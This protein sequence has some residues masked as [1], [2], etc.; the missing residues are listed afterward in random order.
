M[1]VGGVNLVGYLRTESGV[2][3]AARRTL[4]ALRRAGIPVEP[5]DVSELQVNR[6]DDRSLGRFAA[7]HPHEI[8]LVCA[9]VELHFALLAH[10]G[11]DFFRDRYNV[12]LWFWEQP[13]FPR[14]WH[15][16]L[17]WYD[18]VW[19]GSSFIA[20]ALAPISPIPVV[21]IPPVL[22]LVEPGSR[23]R[24]RRRL[25]VAP[26]TL[27]YLFLFDFHSH[28][29]RKNPLAVVEAFRQ[30]FVPTD[31][32]RLVL[33]CV[34][35]QSRPEDLAELRRRAVGWPVTIETGYW[36]AEEIRDLTAAS[37]AYVS[38]HRSEGVGL[39]LG[40][41]MALGKPVIA[42]GWSGNM[43]FMNVGN[44][45]PVRYELTELLENAGPY[46]AG[47][48][49]AEPSIEH[50]AELMRRVLEN[51][52]EA[53]A[54]GA[55]ARREIAAG[56]SEDAVAG[57][58]GE[59]L[60][61][62]AIRRRLDA[63]REEARTEY[64]RYRRLPERLGEA[65][66][67]T[68]PP[69]AVVAVVSKGDEALV[70]IEGRTGWHFPRDRDGA[71]PGYYP[72][73]GEAAVEHLEA[74]RAAGAGFLLIPRTA[75]W[76]LEHYHDFRRHL[77]GRYRRLWHDE[78]CV[79]Y[80]LAAGRQAAEMGALDDLTA[81]VESLARRA[82][83]LWA[84]LLAAGEPRHRVRKRATARPAF[85]KATPDAEGTIARKR[86]DYRRLVGRIRDAADDIL[87]RGATVLV[88]SKGDGELLR[89]GER[90]G[91]HFP[92]T[93]DGRYAGCH[94]ADDAAAITHLEAL[95]AAGAG[96]LLLPST[97]FWW[98]DHYAGFRRHLDDRYRRIWDHGDGVVY[99][100]VE[101]AP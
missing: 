82:A 3:E 83:D 27:V 84:P 70:R 45:Y 73:D 4:R 92:Q 17:A 68:V 90:Q 8:N 20:N 5:V 49:W 18:E 75:F 39:T 29:E 67:A 30:A 38:L 57:V 101:P 87:P 89:L 55:A 24:G 78:D 81:E 51:P 54:R 13:R 71:Y 69:H 56:F 33:K 42:T 31:P 52:R 11:E 6:S 43:D 10:L 64:R 85:R 12:G 48:V 47:D 99:E 37:D 1:S 59:R 44:S 94:P 22:S 72:A 65:A 34:N 60:A 32:V 98:L 40:D 96:H 9:D 95:R 77:E 46:R 74:L 63:F 86:E 50:A 36:P 100:L 21:R 88:V 91:W 79:I 16:R 53:A 2:G 61:A 26:D 76:W 93:D 41:A 62:I 58:I 15:D 19:A 14:R 23:E 7:A 25:G 80:E 28:P 97:A 66:R 35:E